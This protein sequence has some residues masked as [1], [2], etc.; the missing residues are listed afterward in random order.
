MADR[1]EDSEDD[2][3]EISE[4]VRVRKQVIAHMLHFTAQLTVQALMEGNVVDK[5]IV[6]GL[7]IQYDKKCA[8]LIINLTTPHTT[9]ENFGEYP[10]TD[11]INTIVCK[12]LEN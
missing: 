8:N 3:G 11:V 10:L 2:D 12:L 6:Y 7:G 5:T 9:V 1:D 4:T